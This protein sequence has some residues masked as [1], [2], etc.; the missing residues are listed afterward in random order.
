MGSPHVQI[1]EPC[2]SS[3]DPV[4][5]GPEYP[6]FVRVGLLLVI[7]VPDLFDEGEFIMGEFTGFRTS[8]I[9]PI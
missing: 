2:N 8:D 5:R 9:P 6:V 3:Q 1:R 4:N 7:V